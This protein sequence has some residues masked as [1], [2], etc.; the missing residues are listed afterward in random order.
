[1]TVIHD[2]LRV[3]HCVPHQHV[4]IP[5]TK[6]DLYTE[7]I[8]IAYVI[9]NALLLRENRTVERRGQERRRR[10]QR[11][12]EEGQGSLGDSPSCPVVTVG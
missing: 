8:P 3:K 12:G 1:M 5:V 6:T 7:I 10:M 4:S 9:H 11:R 2:S